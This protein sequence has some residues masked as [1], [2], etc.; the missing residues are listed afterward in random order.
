[1]IFLRKIWIASSPPSDMLPLPYSCKSLPKWTTVQNGA[2]Q[3]ILGVC[4]HARGKD[5]FQGGYRKQR[6]KTENHCFPKQRGACN[7]ICKHHSQNKKHCWE[8][9][10]WHI[11]GKI[12]KVLLYSTG[13]YGT[14][15]NI[16]WYTIKKIWKRYVKPSHFAVEQ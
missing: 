7:I 11:C 13:N 1:M 8:Y 4:M 10:I 14:I 12:N 3:Y 2:V 6:R 9:G 16:L 5:F 15:L